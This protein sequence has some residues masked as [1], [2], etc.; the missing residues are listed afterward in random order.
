MVCGPPSIRTISPNPG[1]LNTILCGEERERVLTHCYTLSCLNISMYNV[2]VHVHVHVC[3]TCR[4]L[5]CMYYMYICRRLSLIYVYVHVHV[6]ITC[7]R[8]KE[9]SKPGHEMALTGLTLGLVVIIFLCL[10]AISHA[11]CTRSEG[12]HTHTHT[13]THMQR[14]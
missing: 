14:L 11:H 3:T 12:P 4:R 10:A 6:C 9:A 13:H 1:S 8:K 2:H 7:R 5:S